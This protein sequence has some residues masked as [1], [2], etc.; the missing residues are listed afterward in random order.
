[1]K[2]VVRLKL[3]ILAILDRKIRFMSETSKTW[4]VFTNK[5]MLI[6][7][8]KSRIASSNHENTDQ[9]SR[10]SKRQS[11]AVLRVTVSTRAAYFNGPW[12][13]NS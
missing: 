8:A 1:M 3:R 7:I 13:H 12:V 4:G 11:I 5:L 2:P 10:F 6:L 9:C